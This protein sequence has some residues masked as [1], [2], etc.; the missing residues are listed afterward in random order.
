M[1]C[2]ARS[3]CWPCAAS[4][5]AA[6]IAPARGPHQHRR[7]AQ[8]PYTPDSGTH[9]HPL[10]P[11]D[12][13][14]RRRWRTIDALVVIRDGRI[15]SVKAEREPRRCRRHACAGAR[16]LRLHLPARPHRHAHASHRPARGHRGSARSTSRA[17]P[18]KRCASR[19]KTPPPPCWRDSPACATSAPMSLGTDTAAARRRSIAAKSL[20]P[21]M[22]VSGP[23]PHHSARRRRPVRPGLPGARGQR[24]F[25][26]RRG[27]RR[28]SNSASAPK[29]CSTTARTCS[30]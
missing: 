24:A 12:R 26:R 14:R 20:G 21:R 15:K 23:V 13:R 22:Q 3:S 17:P 7:C 16:S 19:T 28:R 8:V 29:S 4:S 27:A 9:R 2:R 6:R 18:R 30:R 1:N 5:A 11:A 25:S 10:R